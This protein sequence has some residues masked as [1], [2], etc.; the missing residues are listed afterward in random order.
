MKIKIKF[1]RS[2]SKSIS[3]P[4]GIKWEDKP[5]MKMV[6][7]TSISGTLKNHYISEI[8]RKFFSTVGRM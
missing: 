2:A 6:K 8:K 4:W 5:E 3:D 7:H 1:I